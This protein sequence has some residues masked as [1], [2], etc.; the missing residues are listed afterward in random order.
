M[1]RLCVGI[2]HFTNTID[3]F[4]DREQTASLV[5]LCLLAY[6]GLIQRACLVLNNGGD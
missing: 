1:K 6:T 5:Q 3:T 4:H 2:H